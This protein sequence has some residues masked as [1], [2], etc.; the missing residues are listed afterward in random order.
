MGWGGGPGGGVGEGVIKALV[1]QG[2]QDGL[3]AGGARKAR[4]DGEE[5]RWRL[6]GGGRT[7]AEQE[8]W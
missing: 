3:Q 5:S 6:L 2:W 4:P 7:A 8:A 1:L